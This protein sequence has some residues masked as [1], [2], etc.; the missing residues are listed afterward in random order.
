MLPGNLQSLQ[1]DTLIEL[2]EVTDFK[3]GPTDP[4]GDEFPDT[5]H[6]CNYTGVFYRTTPDGTPN[7]Y[8]AIG[9]EADGFDVSGQ[10][11][12]PQPRLTISNVGRMLSDWLFQLKFDP[13]YRLEGATLIRRMTQIS[14]LEGGPNM[15]Q[16]VREL[17]LNVYQIEQ[18]EEESPT[19]A[20]FVLASPFDLD[21]ATL[22]NR[23]ALRSCP[24]RYRDPNTCGYTGQMYDRRNQSTSDPAQD[25]CNKSL[26]AC[27]TRFS[28]GAIRFGGFP[29]LGGF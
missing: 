14:Y 21:G 27:E 15:L 26:T 4:Y 6:F 1:P 10:G 3:L 2:F 24:F 13:R 11:E 25:I 19:A 7:E 16:P 17:P 29:G 20:R 28:T 8:M 5:I 12:L 9:C 22:P 18:L 23:P